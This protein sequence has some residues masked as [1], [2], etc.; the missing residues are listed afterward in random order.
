[1]QVLAQYFLPLED[2]G[3][4]LDA[5]RIFKMITWHD[6]GEI[7][8][9]DVIGFSKTAQDKAND[10]AGNEKVVSETS[11][12]LQN[13]MRTLIE[14]Y[15]S[16][17]NPESKFVKAIDKVEVVFEILDENYREVF[18]INKTTTEHSNKSKYPYVNDYPYIKRFTEVV[19]AYLTKEG[20]FIDKPYNE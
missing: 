4:K 20:Y 13:S 2:D 17:R 18:K 19:S 15:E 10:A 3:A 5:Q 1:M 16:Q 9:G 8:S 7:E 11:E 14:D 6:I 12:V